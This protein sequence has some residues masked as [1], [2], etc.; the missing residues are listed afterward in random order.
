[1]AAIPSGKIEFPMHRSIRERWVRF[2]IGSKQSHGRLGTMK[3]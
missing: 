2:L 1:V 3:A